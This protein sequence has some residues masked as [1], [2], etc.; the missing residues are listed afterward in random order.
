MRKN[1]LA[2]L[3]ASIFAVAIVSGLV[4]CKKDAPKDQPKVEEQKDA[5]ADQAKEEKKAE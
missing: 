3:F 5:P 4:G 2:L 1:V